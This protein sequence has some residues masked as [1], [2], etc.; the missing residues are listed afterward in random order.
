MSSSDPKYNDL[1]VSKF[2]NKTMKKG[3]KFLAQKIV[4]KTFDLIGKKT[5]EDPLDVF[6][7]AVRNTSPRME[8][9]PRRVGGAT[10]QVPTEVGSKRQTSLAMNW[11]L[12]A[13]RSH[14][15][16]NMENRLAEELILSAKGEGMAVKKKTDVEKMAEAN[17]AFAHLARRH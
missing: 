2:I 3:K 12:K 13:A 10:Y 8:T 16:E 17:R 5:K 11:L 1:L 6:N 9:K 15:K 7:Q 14:K 4:Y